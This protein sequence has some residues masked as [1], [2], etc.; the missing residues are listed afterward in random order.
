MHLVRQGSGQTSLAM[1]LSMLG[2]RC[3]SDFT[4]LPAPEM[5]RLLAGKKDRVFDAYV[6]IG[7]LKE[8]VKILRSLYP[9][10]KFIIAATNDTTADHIVHGL[11]DDLNGADIAV[12]HSNEL[13][14]WHVV[15]QHLRC[16]P[17]VCSFPVLKDLGQRPILAEITKLDHVK[18]F[19]IPRHDNSPWLVESRSWWK[20]INVVQ[21]KGEQ[22]EN[23]ML[24]NISDRLEHLDTRRWLLRSDTFTDN[25]ALF[26]PSNVEFRPGI[27]A[28][29]SIKKESLGVRDYSA[30]SLC[31]LDQYLFG[32]F[33]ATIK[34]SNV[35]G[36]VTEY[37]CSEIRRDKK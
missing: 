10:A 23:E 27:G 24:V 37:S 7:S 29:F 32:K 21:G 8:K 26:R 3:C 11:E 18:K 30:A 12:L 31:S 33:E 9:K 19:K 17:P 13:N 35:P 22:R 6:N 20:G 25:L 2:Y 5:E 4:N 1:A 28:V 36:V 34:A 14:K 15:C 16:A